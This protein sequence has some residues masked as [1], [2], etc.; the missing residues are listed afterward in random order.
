M[1]N[2]METVVCQYIGQ[3]GFSRVLAAV[4]SKHVGRHFLPILSSLP[5][6][7]VGMIIALCHISGIFPSEIERLK[8]L[9][10]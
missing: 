3:Q 6:F 8:M 9:V 2:W 10:R 1:L 5:G 7:R 4:N